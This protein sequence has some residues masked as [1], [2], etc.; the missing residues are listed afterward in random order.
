MG[1][2]VEDFI[3]SVRKTVDAKPQIISGKV[4]AYDS[5]AQ[6]VTVKPSDEKAEIFDVRLK[7]METASGALLIVPK[8]QSGCLVSFINAQGQTP[9]LLECDEAESILLNKGRFG[10][11]IKIEELTTQLQLL[12]RWLETFTEAV[13]SAVI[14][15]NDGGAALKSAIVSAVE[16]LDL[17]DYSGIENETVKHGDSIE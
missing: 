3:N 11:L 7:S 17:P 13:K 4:T 16:T 8:L 14:V 15:P 2:G 9:Y 5:D 1:K 12:N 10:G 6:T